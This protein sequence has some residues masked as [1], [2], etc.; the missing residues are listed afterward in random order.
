MQAGEAQAPGQ[1]TKINAGGVKNQAAPGAPVTAEQTAQN[2]A[3][4]ERIASS[5]Q[6]AEINNSQHQLGVNAQPNYNQSAQQQTAQANQPVSG[7]DHEQNRNAK[8]GTE[9]P[10]ASQHMKGDKREREQQAR[11]HQQTHPTIIGCLVAGGKSGKEFYLNEQG[12]GTRHRLSAPTEQLK[13]H[14]NHLVEVVGKPANREGKATAVAGQDQ[15]AFQVS[16]IQDLA[17]TCGASR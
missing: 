8:S 4:A 1:Q 10:G 14:F 9:L 2:P 17:P 15:P 12:S 16:G 13:D 5:A 3:D 11:Q 6:R 7:P